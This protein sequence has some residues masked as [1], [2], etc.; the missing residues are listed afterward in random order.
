MV[1][2]KGVTDFTKLRSI[3]VNRTTYALNGT[4][5]I[6]QDIGNDILVREYFN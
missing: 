2:E 1:G 5:E 4:I 3:K 6:M